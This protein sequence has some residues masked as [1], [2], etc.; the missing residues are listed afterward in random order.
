MGLLL[1]GETVRQ[2]PRIY[3]GYSYISRQ[4][5]TG[6]LISPLRLLKIRGQEQYHG[7]AYLQLRNYL[8]LPHTTWS[9]ILMGQESVKAIFRFHFLFDLTNPRFV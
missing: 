2:C 5:K 7:I 4:R 9:D 1:S 6:F 8:A 3:R